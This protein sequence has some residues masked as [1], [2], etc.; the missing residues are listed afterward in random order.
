MINHFFGDFMDAMGHDFDLALALSTGLRRV[1]GRVIRRAAG[2]GVGVV[3][4]SESFFHNRVRPVLRT[5]K[6]QASREAVAG[7]RARAVPKTKEVYGEN[8]W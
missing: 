1:S 4:W 8:S 6:H 5:Y 7:T 2:T 3:S